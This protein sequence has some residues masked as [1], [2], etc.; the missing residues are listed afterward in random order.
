MKLSTSRTGGIAADMPQWRDTLLSEIPKKLNW[1]FL[2]RIPFLYHIVFLEAAS[3]M[4]GAN[5]SLGLVD[6]SLVNDS[7]FDAGYLMAFYARTWYE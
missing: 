6:R 2:G 4:N 3:Q 1:Q 7:S 5:S